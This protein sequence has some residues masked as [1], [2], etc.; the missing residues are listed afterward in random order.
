MTLAYLL[1][2]LHAAI[3]RTNTNVYKQ[4]NPRAFSRHAREMFDVYGLARPLGG[5]G[6]SYRHCDST[7]VPLSNQ[8]DPAWSSLLGFCL[9]IGCSF[10]YLP[11]LETSLSNSP[12]ES[13][14]QAVFT[15]FPR[16]DIR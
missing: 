14:F 13:Y 5:C 8:T 3:L 1:R 12:R 6:T 7:C 15:C 2:I 4:C 9:R 11:W 16:E 10:E